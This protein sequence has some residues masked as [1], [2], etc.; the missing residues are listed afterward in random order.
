M[1]TQ[2]CSQQLL[3]ISS[4]YQANARYIYYSYKTHEYHFSR[5]FFLITIG[6]VIKI[7]TASPITVTTS[8]TL[9]K[10]SLRISKVF[11]GATLVR[12]KSSPYA[13]TSEVDSKSAGDV[14]ID[15]M[16]A[17]WASIWERLD[18]ARR[19]SNHLHRSCVKSPCEGHRVV[20]DRTERGIPPALQMRVCGRLDGAGLA[21]FGRKIEFFHWHSQLWRCQQRRTGVMVQGHTYNVFTWY[22]EFGGCKCDGRYGVRVDKRLFVCRVFHHFLRIRA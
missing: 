5:S 11:D 15:R 18:R 21:I 20:T 4:A 2:S 14:V 3:P 8:C 12:N 19:A 16:C 17:T 1:R 7:A 6:L 9:L 22:S 10:L 13:N